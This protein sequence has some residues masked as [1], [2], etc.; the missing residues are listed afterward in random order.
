M[1]D[2]PSSAILIHG[3]ATPPERRPL[4][5]GPLT[6]VFQEGDLRTLCLGGREVIRR[7]Y[8]AVRDRDWGTVPGTITDL[9]LQSTEA[10]F[11][12]T[13]TRTHRAGGIHFV[14][15]AVL[16]GGADG[17]LSFC[18]DGE[19][20]STFLRNRIGL[21][22]LHPIRET[23]GAR[24]RAR[25]TN[26]TAQELSFPATV[27]PEQPVRW[28]HDLAGLDHE[29]TPQVWAS[30]DF[31]GET[32]ETEDQRNWIDASFKTYST[33][34]RLPMPMEIRAGT[35]IRQEIRVRWTAPDGTP[36]DLTALPRADRIPP[37]FA[38]HDPAA[39]V[40]IR[41]LPDK[42][43]L[44][45]LGLIA[46]PES[47]LPEPET[48]ARLQALRLAHLRVDVGAGDAD[49]LIH[50]TEQSSDAQVLG[51]R[52]ELALH[53]DDCS[54]WSSWE[55]CLDAL[56]EQLR[57]LKTP[58]ARILIFGPGDAF[59]TTPEGLQLARR[60]LGALGVPI[61]SGTCGDLYQ[62]HCRR[63]PGDG[64]FTVWAMNPQVHAFDNASIAETPE[65]AAHQV[66]AVRGQVPGQP[67]VVSPVTLVPRGNPAGATAEGSAP[68]SDARQGSLFGA[69]WTLAMIRALAGSGVHSMTL[70][71]TTG[72]RG[73][74][75]PP[76]EEASASPPF[77]WLS[78]GVF[79]LY[80][81]LADLADFDAAEGIATTTSEPDSVVS[82]LL[83]SGTRHRLLLANL[84][85]EFRHV[86]L[87]H[88]E[89]P[90]TARL[91][92]LDAATV[93]AAM[94]DPER[95]RTTWLPVPDTPVALPPHALL[96]LDFQPPSPER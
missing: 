58:L 29:V 78:A 19:A 90:G 42:I 12:I 69:A 91:R 87:P 37:N 17:V 5:A 11:R 67:L 28:L 38:A 57:S 59:N 41:I 86:T 89:L 3:L 26:G 63:P 61:G 60:H 76:A 93:W 2:A 30:V 51:H 9:D 82:L 80:H 20:R 16:T 21:C 71:E 96:T 64:D 4:R 31:S 25:Y 46:A 84:T 62:F 52:I 50:L 55:S 8:G 92:R 79:P 7:L 27:A 1:P 83:R 45:Q 49:T 48:L 74:M 70:Y 18:F 88:T 44:P 15:T 54:N 22:V 47:A 72:G 56:A 65:A 68:T 32:F 77:P 43:S 36:L 66:A 6:M 33:P 13:Y 24:G 81:V 23:A 10:G 14:W 85:P 34:L 94:T 35:R 40:A 39:P 53:L 73:V 95:F 75:M